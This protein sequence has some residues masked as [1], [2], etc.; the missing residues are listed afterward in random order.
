VSF[1]IVAP[2]T[3][4]PNPALDLAAI[5]TELTECGPPSEVL[6]QPPRLAARSLGLDRVLL[7]SVRGGE[8]VAEGLHVSQAA[9]PATC[10]RSSNSVP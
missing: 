6:I 10:S 7:T 3:P 2:P 4:T 8:L 5:L 9:P 1:S